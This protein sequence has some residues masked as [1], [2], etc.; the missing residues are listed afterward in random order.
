MP[1]IVIIAETGQ[2]FASP[3]P[4]NCLPSLEAEAEILALSVGLAGLDDVTAWGYTLGA[5][6]GEALRSYS[7]VRWCHGQPTNEGRAL[8]GIGC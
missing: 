6:A 5:D 8:Y 2:R 1:C 7:S 4:T 3:L